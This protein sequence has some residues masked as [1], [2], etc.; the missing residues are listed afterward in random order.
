MKLLYF[1][2]KR[3]VT[4][5]FSPNFELNISG[6]P[7]QQTL[8]MII[9]ANS[10][11]LCK[12]FKKSV[13]SDY[14][15]SNFIVFCE[16]FYIISRIYFWCNILRRFLLS[17][18]LLCSLYA[19]YTSRSIFYFWKNSIITCEKYEELLINFAKFFFEY[20]NWEAV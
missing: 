2:K 4:N 1:N 13:N 11:F 3:I 20:K 14:F 19:A 15:H 9:V 7:D 10:C 6:T 17:K 8:G 16:L 18:Y 12:F 5:F